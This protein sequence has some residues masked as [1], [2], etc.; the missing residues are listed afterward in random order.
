MIGEQD[1][2]P[3]DPLARWWDMPVA[4]AV[5]PIESKDSE[6]HK[7][8]DVFRSVHGGGAHFLMVGGAVRWLNSDIDLRVYHALATIAGSEAVSDL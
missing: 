6:G 4:S 8:A 5:D 1:S 3:V 2:T 7:R